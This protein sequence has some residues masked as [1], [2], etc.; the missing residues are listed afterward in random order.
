MPPKPKHKGCLSCNGCKWRLE[1]M[2]LKPKHKGCLSCN[3]CKWRMKKMPPKPKHFHFQ[4]NLGISSLRI[5]LES[6]SD[7]KQVKAS[8][9]GC[10]CVWGWEVVGGWGGELIYDRNTDGGHKGGQ[11][12]FSTKS[13]EECYSWRYFCRQLFGILWTRRIHLRARS[14]LEVKWKFQRPQ[15]SK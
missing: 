9:F 6:D 11:R 12:C 1:K 3:G 13:K 8:F 4:Y 5:Q 2:L 14:G 10:V 7:H 15:C